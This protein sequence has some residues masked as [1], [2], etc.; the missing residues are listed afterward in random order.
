M[1]R[2]SF[3]PGLM[4]D[5]R[6]AEQRLGGGRDFL[7]GAAELDAARLAPPA[8]VNLR[9]DRPVPSAQL[10]RDVDRLFRTIGH[11]S[12]RH[13][14]AESGQEF[15]RLVFV[16]VHGSLLLVCR[17]NVPQAPRARKWR[18]E[19]SQLTICKFSEYFLTL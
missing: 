6:G 9:L 18:G 1:H 4:G 2:L 11:T 7:V 19:Y 12:R 15:F 3:G 17:A 10:G 13:G 16:N 5:E 8:R 14:H